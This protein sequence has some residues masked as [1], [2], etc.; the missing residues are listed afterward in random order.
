MSQLILT[1]DKPDVNAERFNVVEDK[2]VMLDLSD[3]A[4][5]KG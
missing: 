1:L 3:T 5:R 4:Q 2:Q